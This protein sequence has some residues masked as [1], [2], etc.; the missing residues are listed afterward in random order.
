MGRPRGPLR[1][2]LGEGASGAGSDALPASSVESAPASSSS[3]APAAHPSEARLDDR[4]LVA[5][6]RAGDV[7]AARSFH[8]RVRPRVDATVRSLLGR[9]DP[10]H[11]DLV[12]L[13]MIGL[14]ET[15]D[16]YRGDC[17]LGSWASLIAAR[18]VY[19]E[20]RRRRRARRVFTTSDDAVEGVATTSVTRTVVLRDLAERVRCHVARLNEDKAWA[21]LLHDVCGFT[22]DEIA[23]ITGASTAAAQKRLVRGRHELH[24]LLAADPELADLVTKQET[25]T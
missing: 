19:K 14:V 10:E 2:I 17:S 3:P 16:R 21:F 24:E 8:D 1:L 15:I 7:G 25:S 9:A 6:V 23:N 4:Q 20:I 11:E 12:Q 18:L 5:C 22:L 13:T